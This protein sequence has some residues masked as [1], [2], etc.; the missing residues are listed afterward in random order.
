MQHKGVPGERRRI[1]AGST[2]LA[3]TPDR[4]DDAILRHLEGRACMASPLIPQH[5]PTTC[6]IVIGARSANATDWSPPLSSQRRS[7]SSKSQEG[8]VLSAWE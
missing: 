4:H 1:G 8:L 2:C 3:R 6:Q 5:N 7:L